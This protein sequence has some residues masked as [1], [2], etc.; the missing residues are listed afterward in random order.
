MGGRLHIVSGLSVNPKW[1]LTPAKSER[2][3]HNLTDRQLLSDPTSKERDAMKRV[4]I[5]C[6]AMFAVSGCQQTMRTTEPAAGQLKTGQTVLVD[7]GSCPA[8]QVKQVTG[9]VPGVPRQKACVARP[10]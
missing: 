2:T 6:A 10:A 1:G 3:C 5:L 9:S 4:I 8:G 7:D